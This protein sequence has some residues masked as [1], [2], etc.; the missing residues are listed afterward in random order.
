M[1]KDAIATLL[2]IEVEAVSDEQWET[3]NKQYESELDRAR[4]QAS[5]TA[6]RNTIEQAKKDA[7]A[8][9]ES[10]ANE[11]AKE[12]LES[13]TKTEEER[14]AAEAAKE[15]EEIAKERAALNLEKKQTAVKSKLAAAGYKGE[16][17]DSLVSV[18]SVKDD[19]SECESAVETFI[20]GLNKTVSEKVDEIKASLTTGGTPPAFGGTATGTEVVNEGKLLNEIYAETAKDTF[21]NDPASFIELDAYAIAALEAANSNTNK[22]E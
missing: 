7:E 13:L 19:V 8:L 1:E 4:T 2:G 12:L 3:F 21:R 6:A 9:L 5:K 18:F 20:E 10:K 14:I 11:K 16:E 15:R 17:L 22:G